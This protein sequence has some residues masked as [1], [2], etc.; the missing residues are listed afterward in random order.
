M[1]IDSDNIATLLLYERFGSALSDQLL[2]EFA[3]PLPPFL[4]N[5]APFITVNDYSSFF[6]I[7][8]NATYLSKENSQA[9]LALLAQTTF[10]LGLKAVK[11]SNSVVSNKFGIFTLTNVDQLHDCGIVYDADK[12]YIICIF[13]KGSDGTELLLAIQTIAKTIFDFK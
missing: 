2:R 13:T 3:L 8:Y 7:L 12:H 4:D 9:A 5:Y 10:D 6:R 1:I 11:P